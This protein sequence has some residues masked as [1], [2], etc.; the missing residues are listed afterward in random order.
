MQKGHKRDKKVV[1]TPEAQSTAGLPV[2]HRRAAGI[3]VGSTFHVAA[4]NT[5]LDPDP[6]R[7]FNTFTGDLNRL[8]DWLVALGVTTV[9]MESTG[10]YWIPV[11]EILEARGL[12]VLL[13]N[14]SHVKNV[15]GRKT[16]FNDAQWIQRL[17]EHGLLRGS[18]RPSEDVAVL[19]AYVRHRVRLVELAASSI[20][21][22]QKA[23]MQMNVQLHHVMSDITGVTGMKIIRAIVDGERDPAVLAAYRNERCKSSEAEIQA[24]LTGNYRPEHVF[25]LQ[26][27]LEL[28]DIYLIKIRACDERIEAALKVLHRHP[29]VPNAP[30]QAHA[31]EQTETEPALPDKRTKTVRRKRK[32]PQRN[33]HDPSFDITRVLAALL[34]VDL[35]EIH[36]FGPNVVLLLIAECGTDMSRWATVKHFT[37]WLTLA[38]GCKISGGKVLS[39]KTRRSANRAA[40]ILRMAAVS[41][42]KTTSA[43]GAFYRRLAARVGKGKAVV[44]T[45]RKLAVLFYNTLR[46][47]T[48]YVDP[49]ATAYEERYRQRSV[50]NLRRRAKGLGFEL[51]P[52]GVEGV[53]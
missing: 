1:N 35:T 10:V 32:A 50:D 51:V 21:H 29:D 53:S 25:A 5:E 52:A 27:A 17:H 41:V 38:P 48:A 43:I 15:P 18:F 36:G 44:A 45:A 13:V 9:A 37:S 22:M 23:L 31:Q 47:G 16:D 24:A 7:S 11:F 39:S 33:K 34:G 30:E 6:V 40:H 14:A 28:H 2:V 12:E 26:Q 4:V 19:R 8:A 42:G 3:D 46:H 20:Q 49:G